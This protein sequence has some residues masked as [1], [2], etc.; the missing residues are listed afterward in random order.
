MSEQRASFYWHHEGCR[1]SPKNESGSQS[2]GLPDDWNMMAVL[3]VFFLQ[4]YSRDKHATLASRAAGKDWKRFDDGVE[5]TRKKKH[6]SLPS[7]FSRQSSFFLFH[8]RLLSFSLETM[9]CIT[10][11]YCTRTVRPCTMQ[12]TVNCISL[13]GKPGNKRC[14]T[15]LMALTCVRLS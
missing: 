7:A 6:R 12:F 4:P 11:M 5:G 2:L 15:R 13:L 8:C 14:S 3:F 1:W 9:M 10:L